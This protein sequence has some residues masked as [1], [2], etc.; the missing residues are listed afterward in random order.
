MT[1]RPK[2]SR[3]RRWLRRGLIGC[4]VLTI[5]VVAIAWALWHNDQQVQVTISPETTWIVEPLRDDGYVDYVAALNQHASQG[6]TLENNAVVLFC[7]AMGPKA[8]HKATSETFFELLGIEPLAAEG[9]YFVTF[10]RYLDEQR[11]EIDVEEQE[12]LEEE[13]V[14]AAKRPW[15]KKDLPLLAQWLTA[16]QN[17]LQLVVE[18]TRRPR[19]YWPIVGAVEDTSLMAVLL[20]GMEGC[21]EFAR[22]LCIR[23][24]LHAQSGRFDDARAD[25]MACHR[26]AR[27]ASRGPTLVEGLV[28]TTIEG[29]ACQADAAIAHHGDLSVE[30]AKLFAAD[31]ANLS[32]LEGFADKIDVADRYMYLD[33]M[34]LIA[35][36]GPA[37]ANEWSVGEAEESLENTIQRCLLNQ[38][39]DWD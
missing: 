36:K 39:V 2:T 12:T 38:Y 3:L 29:M 8:I 37:A 27:L 34:C 30:Q 13:F 21:R 20:P 19:C 4:A 33:S 1:A 18:G 9:E 25:L 23:A 35:R 5:V 14:Q 17:P 10:D 28:A 22:G 6:V 26:L 24:M 32:P 16:N 15:S 31:L 11:P 7:R